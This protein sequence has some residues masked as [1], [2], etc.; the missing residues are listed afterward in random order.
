MIG[1]FGHQ[2]WWPGDSPFE[3]CVGAILTQNTNWRNVERAI[4]NLKE[5]QSLDL[6]VM[7]SLEND[8]LATLIRPAGYYNLKAQRLKAFTKTIV[9]A[10]DGRLDRLFEA[11]T[12][13]VREQLLKVNG[14]GPETADSILLYAGAHPSFVIDAYTKRIFT[15]HSWVNQKA[16]YNDMKQLCEQSLSQKTGL[17]RLDYWQDYHAHA[18]DASHENLAPRQACEVRSVVVLVDVLVQVQKEY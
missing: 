18:H 3:I 8:H 7:N 17:D 15:R 16:G 4:K 6:H 14:I 5:H 9:D 10:H 12:H 1:K 13:T 11:D 2:A